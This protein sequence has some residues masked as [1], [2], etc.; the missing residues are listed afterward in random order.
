MGRELAV[1]L[2]NCLC[3]KGSW[4]SVVVPVNRGRGAIRGLCGWGFLL[5]KRRLVAFVVAM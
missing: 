5:V 3:D 1:D 2:R 4:P